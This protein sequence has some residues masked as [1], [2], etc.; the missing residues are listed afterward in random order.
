M[1]RRVVVGALAVLAPACSLLFPLDEFRSGATATGDAAEGGGAPSTGDAGDASAEDAVT[2][3]QRYR[4][5]VLA[6]EPVLYLRF[7]EKAGSTASDERKQRNGTY[8]SGVVL[9]APGAI[10]GDVDTAARFDGKANSVV[11]I[12][13]GLDFPGTLPFS[14][15][16]WVLQT[17]T[18]GLGWAID[19]QIYGSNRNGWGLLFNDTQIG[20]E[21]WR[22]DTHTGVSTGLTLTKGTYQHVVVTFDG[23]RNVLYVD[24]VAAGERIEAVSMVP[25]TSSW[26]AGAQNCGCAPDNFIGSL[27]ELA[28]YDKAL[29]A[30][31]VL[32]HFHAAG[33]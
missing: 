13:P 30:G 24:G 15:E 31:R 10:A 3:P 26:T 17:A 18:P 16:V 14:V 28:I 8:G 23:S 25:M 6:D 20:F 33:R 22:D 2:I 4:E 21:R 12:P 9:D 29:P 32:A 11:T 5:E 7:G 1:M 19:H 27:D